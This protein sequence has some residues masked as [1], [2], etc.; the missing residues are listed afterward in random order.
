M[1]DKE[2]PIQGVSVYAE[3][4]KT[5]YRTEMFITPDGFT[6][7]G[8]LVPAKIYRRV[9][10]KEKP[11]KLWQQTTVQFAEELAQVGSK[12]LAELGLKD[13]YVSKR[14]EHL[15]SIFAGLV[16]GDWQLVNDPILIETSQNDLVE[17]YKGETPIKI[18]YRINQSRKALGFPAEIAQGAIKMDTI[19]KDKLASLRGDFWTIVSDCLTQSVHEDTSLRLSAKVLPSGR[20]VERASGDKRKARERVGAMTPSGVEVDNLSADEFYVRPN[21]QK[22]FTRQWGV[23]TDVAVLRKAREATKKF[24]SE[25]VGSPQFAFFYGV[26]GTGKTA[27]VEASFHDDDVI[28]LIG[29]GDTDTNDFYGS[30]IQT[31][32]GNF[33]WIDA[34]FIRA[35]EFGKPFFIDEIGLIDPKAL[36]VVYSVMDGRKEI[37]IPMNPERGTIKVHDD[38]YVVS[39]TNPNAP[40]VRMSEALLSRFQI[41]AELTTDWALAKKL[42]VPATMVSV[43][44][45]LYKRTQGD[46][47]EISWSPQMR[48]LLGFR[49]TSEIFGTEFAI[50]NLIASAPEIDRDVVVDVIARAFGAE[51]KPAK[52][53]VFPRTQ[54]W[55]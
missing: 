37:T 54:S 9:V 36:A 30:F 23:H 21:G 51:H 34:G 13:T 32:S 33:E 43:A 26:P 25:G 39:A 10:S 16:E 45:N 28:T 38:F 12:D 2:K 41:Q 40:G 55:L 53:Q 11:K 48:E 49:D 35:V 24:F 20:C 22:Y 5:G 6:P 27:L 46:S 29:N 47:A 50:S 17:I 14:L 4:A 1:L 19:I 7:S 3:F 8:D 15:N 42:G 44:Q 18:V 52:I 31:P